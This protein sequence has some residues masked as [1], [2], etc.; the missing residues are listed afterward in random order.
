ML[1]QVRE[2]L[3]GEIIDVPADIPIRLQLLDDGGRVLEA[4]THDLLMDSDGVYRRL[5]RHQ[6][7]EV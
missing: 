5:V 4:G 7:V 6:L 2:K 1:V 3:S